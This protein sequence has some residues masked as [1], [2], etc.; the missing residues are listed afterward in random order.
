[1]ARPGAGRVGACRLLCK[2]CAPHMALHSVTQES[3]DPSE[4]PWLSGAGVRPDGVLA[5]SAGKCVFFRTQ[6][7]GRDSGKV[8]LPS[9]EQPCT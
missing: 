8:V 3:Q 4:N 7:D 5:A 6:D 2:R 1:V 9:L